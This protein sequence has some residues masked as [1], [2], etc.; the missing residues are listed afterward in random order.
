L[1][2]LLAENKELVLGEPGLIAKCHA[3]H[4]LECLQEDLRAVT[5][6]W[7]KSSYL[8]SSSPRRQLN[9]SAAEQI[10]MRAQYLETG[11]QRQDFSQQ[12]R[13]EAAG[14]HGLFESGG[15]QNRDTRHAWTIQILGLND[16][17]FLPIF[18]AAL[19]FSPPGCRGP[20]RKAGAVPRRRKRSSTP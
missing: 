12:K 4:E 9:G 20:S 3:F 2:G 18:T 16:K 13:D 1:E 19:S 7:G 14:L 10:A 17:I 8:G 15:G 5:A 6:V 11:L